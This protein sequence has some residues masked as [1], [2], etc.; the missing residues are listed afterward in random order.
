LGIQDNGG[1]LSW[2]PEVF[3]YVYLHENGHSAL[4]NYDYRRLIFAKGTAR[5]MTKL[6]VER[7]ADAIAMTTTRSVS[8]TFTSP[9]FN[10]PDHAQW[11]QEHLRNYDVL[12]ADVPDRTYMYYASTSARAKARQEERSKI[13]I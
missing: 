7:D 12:L 6:A 5:N 13:K 8:K 10:L 3:G 9:V 4:A 1:T 2:R 11:A